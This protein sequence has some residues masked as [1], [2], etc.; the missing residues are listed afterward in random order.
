MALV[1]FSFAMTALLTAIVRTT[2]YVDL[3]HAPPTDTFILSLNGAFFRLLRRDDILL[4][5]EAR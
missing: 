5:R 3:V 1:A 2:W 4:K